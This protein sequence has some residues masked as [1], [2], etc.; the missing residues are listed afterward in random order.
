MVLFTNQIFKNSF[1]QKAGPSIYFKTRGW[2]FQTLLRW[3]FEALTE[4]QKLNQEF[5]KFGQVFKK[6]VEVIKIFGH[7]LVFYTAHGVPISHGK[8]Y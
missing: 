5:E 3:S 1:R 2:V 4:N 7:V 8:K 6:L